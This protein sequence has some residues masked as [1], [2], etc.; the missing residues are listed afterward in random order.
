LIFLVINRLNYSFNSNITDGKVIG[1]KI[2][3]N[4][5]FPEDTETAPIIE[6]Y[7]DDG[8]I[9]FTAQ[10]NLK[11]DIGHELKVIYKKQNPNKANIY[12]FFGFWMEPLILCF[13]P[14]IVLSALIFVFI[15]KKDTIVCSRNKGNKINI[16]RKSIEESKL[17]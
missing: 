6:F 2:W 3:E 9:E 13:I 12:S 7:S 11:Y 5:T 8:R 10:R 14:I 17:I 1:H 16:S 4:E 15:S